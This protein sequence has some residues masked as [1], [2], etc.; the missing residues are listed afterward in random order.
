MGSRSE[1][2]HHALGGLLGLAYFVGLWT[3][4]GQTIGM[5]P[6]NVW[7]VRV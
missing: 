6:F 3:L 4:K 5:M 1:S 7:V 2:S